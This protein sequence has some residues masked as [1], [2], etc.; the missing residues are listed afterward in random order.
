[1]DTLRTRN[2]SGDAGRYILPVLVMIILIFTLLPAQ[3]ALKVLACEPEWGALAAELGGERIE[4]AV[5]TTAR[6]DPH[7]IEARPSLM[8][9]ARRADLLVCTGAELE[10]GWLPLLLQDSGNGAIL[11][12]RPGYFEAA[13]QVE[14]IERPA[15]LDRAHGDVHA[16]GNPHLHLDPYR[17]LAIADALARRL[18]QMDPDHAEHYRARHDD[19][20][21]R[22]RAAIARWETQATPLRG[23][24]VAVHHKNWSYLAQWLRFDIAFDLEPKP[25]IE[26][27]V[28]H[29][30]ALLAGMRERPARMVLKTAYQSPRAGRWL[31]ER[32]GI[33]LVE[34]P[35]T[36]GGSERARDLF[37]LYEDTIARLLAGLE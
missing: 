15:V 6:Q 11:R 19:F 13:A 27:S 9:Q 25:G 5:A 2:R 36:V 10:I 30:S 18:A 26:P 17:L 7:R 4:L 35:Y 16:A 32:A 21:Q 1:M 28:S 14:L 20:E 23:Q 24:A 8:A 33:P 29:L 34:L 22:W 12:G 3:A 31:S 37:G